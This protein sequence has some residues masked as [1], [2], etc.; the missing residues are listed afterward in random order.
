M[1]LPSDSHP[2]PLLCAAPQAV[3]LFD[4]W[5]RVSEAA[6][7]NDKAVIIFLSQMQH[8]GVLKTEETAER[9]FRV[10]SVSEEDARARACAWCPAHPSFV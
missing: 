7:T 10:L 1:R 8:S 3:V 5:V 6:L 2:P 9:F 4:E